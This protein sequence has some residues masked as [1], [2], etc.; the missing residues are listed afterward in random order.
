MLETY[1]HL[2]TV[3]DKRTGGQ[4]ATL[5]DRAVSLE[6]LHAAA[7]ILSRSAAKARR[8]HGLNANGM[9]FNVNLADSVFRHP[10]MIAIMR[11]PVD[12]ARSAWR[13]NQRLAREEPENA[14]AHLALLNNPE[15]TLDG[16]AI[17]HSAHYTASVTRFL[18]YAENRGSFLVVLYENL[19]AHKE[20]ELRRLF[21]FLGADTSNDVIHRIAIASSPE[22]MAR[23]STNPEFFGFGSTGKEA[24]RVSPH[25]RERILKETWP[26][27]GRLAYNM[28]ELMPYIG[29][30]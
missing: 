20:A 21:E 26:V 8:I 18:D 25:V 13:H 3:M 4:G 22:E 15:G 27:L 14:S 29:R 12:Q 2:L 7:L 19:V 24:L 23:N 10:K 6:I 30:T 5:P 9:F 16:F 28:S 17:A 11:N 1:K